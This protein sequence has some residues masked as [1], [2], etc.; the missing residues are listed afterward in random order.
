MP[1]HLLLARGLIVSLLTSTPII[2]FAFQNRSGKS[3]HPCR[4]CAVQ[5]GGGGGTKLGHTTN[6]VHLTDTCRWHLY[7]SFDAHSLWRINN[8]YRC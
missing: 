6:P 5:G 8:T 2:T 4:Q 1:P 3:L 7:D